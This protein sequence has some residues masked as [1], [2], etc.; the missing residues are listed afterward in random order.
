MKHAQSC[1][2]V[3]FNRTLFNPTHTFTASIGN[4]R[5][6]QPAATNQVHFIK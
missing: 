5:N 1:E 2:K 4:N 3:D 6:W